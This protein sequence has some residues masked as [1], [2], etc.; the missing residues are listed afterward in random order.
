[1]TNFLM[2]LRQNARMFSSQPGDGEKTQNFRR[3]K[4]PI[5]NLHC[6][7]RMQFWE[8]YRKIFAES[9]KNLR[10]KIKNKETFQKICFKRTF[11]PNI[12]HGHLKTVLTTQQDYFRQKSKN[13]SP[14]SE[15]TTEIF[16]DFVKKKIISSKMSSGHKE[17]CFDHHVKKKITKFQTF[18]LKVH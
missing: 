9:T 15:N 1:M 4:C 11:L 14:K 8:T 10:P 16:E 3:K 12:S 5:E 2:F 18:S 13:F 7:H 17:N 6:T